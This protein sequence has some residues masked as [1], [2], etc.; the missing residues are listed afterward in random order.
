MDRRE[1]IS[2]IIWRNIFLYKAT[3]HIPISQHLW[4]W[5][6]NNCIIF[7][8]YQQPYNPTVSHW[9]KE[10]QQTQW[11]HALFKNNYQKV[12]CVP[13]YMCIARKKGQMIVKDKT[14]MKSSNQEKFK[15][16]NNCT[17]ACEDLLELPNLPHT[18][19]WCWLY[20]QFGHIKLCMSCKIW[21]K[22]NI[23]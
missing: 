16:F 3:L 6:G 22:T 21:S 20:S 4:H 19:H 1:Y 2:V 17:S 7:H 5:L 13:K 14:K 15:I 11:G 18:K 8:T 9:H 12:I 10:S 23:N